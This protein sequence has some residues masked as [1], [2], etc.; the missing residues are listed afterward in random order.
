VRLGLPGPEQVIADRTTPGVHPARSTD[1]VGHLGA[2]DLADRSGWSSRPVDL[3]LDLLYPD[4]NASRSANPRD[5]RVLHGRG[6]LHPPGSPGRAR[7]GCN[8]SAGCAVP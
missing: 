1:Q 4:E 2:V 3:P 7:A 5:S 6:R 8:T